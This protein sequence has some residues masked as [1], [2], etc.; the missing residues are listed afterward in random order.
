VKGVLGTGVKFLRVGGN[1]NS[2]LIWGKG[3]KGHAKSKRASKVSHN[4]KQR[5]DI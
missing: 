1:F 5:G 3:K 4:N 2:V